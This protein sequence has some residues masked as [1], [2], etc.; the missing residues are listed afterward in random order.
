MSICLSGMNPGLVLRISDRHELRLLRIAD[1]AAVF[2]LTEE[3][4]AFLREWLP[5]VDWTTTASD[6]RA[7]IRASLKRFA[8]GRGSSLAI[9]FDGQIVGTIGYND[10]NKHDR[11]GEIG[12]WLAEAY[13]GKGIMT[14]SCRVLIDYGFKGLN[15]N[16][17]VIQCAVGNHRSR[18]VP[19]RLGFQYE[20]TAREAGRI[21]D[22]FV[23]HEVYALL[24]RDWQKCRSNYSV[25]A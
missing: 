4:R 5:W 22:R 2:A 13:Q 16:R 9:W 10:L 14:R 15:L 12:Y 19:R 1:A 3:N 17:V 7:F 25:S 18:A 20:G 24:R 8:D 6:T 11:K 21:R 23:D